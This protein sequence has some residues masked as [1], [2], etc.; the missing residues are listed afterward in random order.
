MI[1]CFQTRRM[2]TILAFLCVATVQITSAT[3]RISPEKLAEY[4]KDA[5]KLLAD[6]TTNYGR[7]CGCLIEPGAVPSE[8][9][10][11]HFKSDLGKTTNTLSQA[12][13]LYLISE[14]YYWGTYNDFKKTRDKS[15]MENS[16]RDV[17][18]AYLAA[19]IAVSKADAED[20]K[21]AKRLRQAIIVKLRQLST[22]SLYGSSL[23][24][25]LKSAIVSQ[26]IDKIEDQKDGTSSWP[27]ELRCKI[28]KNLGIED[29]LRAKLSTETPTN[30]DD[31]MDALRLASS[32]GCTQD[33]LRLAAVLEKDH[34]AELEKRSDWRG[35]LFKIYRNVGDSRALPLIK[36]L[37]QDD[38]NAY[39]ELYDFSRKAEPDMGVPERR[40]YIEAYLAA[41]KKKDEQTSQPY[42]L[43]AQKLMGAEDYSGALGVIEEGLK[44]S[45]TA[46]SH[47]PY[48]WY[49]KGGCCEKLGQPDQATEAYRQCAELAA[50]IEGGNRLQ[51]LCKKK[52][53]GKESAGTLDAKAQFELGLRYENGLGGAQ[54]YTN[55]ALCYRKAAERGNV[56]AQFSLGLCYEHGNGVTQDYTNA[57]MWYRKAAEQGDSFAQC[58]I[59]VCCERGIG[60]PKD[61]KA[62]DEWYRKSAQQG[63]VRAQELLKQIKNTL[64]PSLQSTNGVAIPTTASVPADAS[65]DS[66]SEE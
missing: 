29:R 64:S 21:A 52:L 7:I 58:N 19:W 42:L 60:V 63:N 40:K 15:V 20:E 1:A 27:I 30:A 53:A 13:L 26:F 54:D 38:P 62:A 35:E 5:D 6:P 3:G 41:I 4:A 25:E 36:A 31:I 24:P 28:Y 47:L 49:A 12:T 9:L 33:V 51:E 22:T 55:A 17:I 50:G 10:L 37:A 43:A 18:P 23:T 34:G 56:K 48:L 66:S 61:S 65:T 39:M 59:G 57:A 8:Q 2:A 16:A 45:S 32:M 14:T 44:L 46:D 11:S